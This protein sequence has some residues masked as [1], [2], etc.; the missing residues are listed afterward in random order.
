MQV[1]SLQREVDRLQ[2]SLARTKAEAAA[3]CKELK[4]VK[5][6]PPFAIRVLFGSLL[7]SSHLSLPCLVLGVNKISLQCLQL[8]P[9]LWFNPSSH[10]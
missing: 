3:D 2:A 7:A 4:A 10:F 9:N 6:R 8:Y 1:Q 5:V